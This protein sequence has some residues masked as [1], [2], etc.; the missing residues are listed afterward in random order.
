[1]RPPASRSPLR[2][3]KLLDGA[4]QRALDEFVLAGKASPHDNR[5]RANQAM[6]VGMLGRYEE[7]LALYKQV[8]KPQQAHYNLAIVCEARQDTE[9][10]TAEFAIARSIGAPLAGPA[11]PAE[12]EDSP[13]R[14][15]E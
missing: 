1:M 9:R 5:I 6:A 10:A 8:V 13:R 14:A 12:R 7:A 3:Q 11:V 15:A 4:Y 2:C